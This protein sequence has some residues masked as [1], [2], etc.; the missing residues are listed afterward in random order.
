[1]IYISSMRAACLCMLTEPFQCDEGRPQCKSCVNFGVVC[2]YDNAPTIRTAGEVI[3]FRDGL[4]PVM[5]P[6]TSPVS[7]NQTILSLTNL[8]LQQS[9]SAV[10]VG[11]QVFRLRQGDLEALHRFSQRSVLTLGNHDTKWVLQA[12]MPRLASLV[13]NPSIIYFF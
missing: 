9:P 1:M 12:E 8:A 2:N 11:S 10:T 5:S 6:S 13:S 7:I 4:S 3:L